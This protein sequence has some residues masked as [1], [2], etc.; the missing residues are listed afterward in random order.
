MTDETKAVDEFLDGLANNGE[1][2][3]LE[4]DQD[5][6]FKEKEVVKEEEVVK[7]DKDLPFHKNPKVTKFIEKEVEKEIAKRIPTQ[8][9]NQAPVVESKLEVNDRIT[10]VLT[11]IIGNDTPE[12]I[13]AI[14]D[15]REVLIEREE[16]GAEKAL[17]RIQSERQEQI[18][19][20]IEAEETLNSGFESIEEEMGVNLFAPQYKKLRGQFI[21]FIE[22]VAP[23]DTQGEITEFPDIV[24][25][26]KMF[27]SIRPTQNS[28]RA[29]EIADRGM[30]RGS[31]SEAPKPE[32][33]LSF[34]DF[35]SIKEKL[36]GN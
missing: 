34:H 9:S 26:F 25:S 8:S 13:S 14:K 20:E 31:V 4:V 2:N 27:Q 1:E 32:K 3:P 28:S 30:Q 36:L 5:D 18:Q 24:E 16:K 11:R 23:K 10:D 15:L 35:E 22:K 29:K 17:E 7:A 19:A 21:D 6:P 33:S 12:K